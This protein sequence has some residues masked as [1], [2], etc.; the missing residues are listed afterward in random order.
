MDRRLLVLIVAAVALIGVVNATAFAYRWITGTV[1]IVGPSEA[2]G[3]ACTGFYSA[4]DQPN[5]DL[6]KLGINANAP[7]YGTNG[8]RVT[9]GSVACQWSTGTLYQSID[10]EVNITTG[11]WYIQ[12]FYAF[13]YW[14]GTT[15]STD[16]VYVYF[17]VERPIDTSKVYSA[18]LAINGTKL[19]LTGYNM[20]GPIEI[21]SG[22][23]T[24]LDLY[25]N[26][27]DTGTAS[28]TVGVYV[29]QESGESPSPL[30]QSYSGE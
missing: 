27:T 4:S 9:P 19:D 25:I 17:R 13:G 7:T 20:V 11:Y 6:P 29:T 5:I 28:F 16:K 14:N 21:N 23:A 18:Y 2:K 3:A 8:T 1:N 26:A 12:D 30:R 10:V 22:N 15:S 24:R